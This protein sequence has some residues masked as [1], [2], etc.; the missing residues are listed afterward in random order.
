MDVLAKGA[1]THSLVH[2]P[3]P[4]DHH[5][6]SFFFLPSPH[7]VQPS[8]GLSHCVS[9]VSE[10]FHRVGEIA[11]TGILLDGCGIPLPEPL[12]LLNRCCVIDNV[13]WGTPVAGVTGQ[14]GGNIDIDSPLLSLPHCSFSSLPPSLWPLSPPTVLIPFASVAVAQGVLRHRSPSPTPCF[15]LY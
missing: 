13:R 1:M 5:L 9:S 12:L 10:L 14:E 7:Y 11:I 6:L 3:L 2:P 4:S 15:P 8:L